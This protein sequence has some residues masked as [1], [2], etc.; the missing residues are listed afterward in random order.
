MSAQ[1]D[2]YDVLGVA[3]NASDDDIKKAFRNLA[4]Q[5]HP[6]VNPDDPAAAERFRGIAEAYE[7]LANPETRARYD[8][9]GHAGVSGAATGN[10]DFGDLGDILGMFFGD[11][12]FGGGRARG[13]RGETSLLDVSRQ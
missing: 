5:H 7:I 4:R 13:P 2:L 12:M 6:D 9:Y 10:V 1:Q 3:R 8:R 11:G